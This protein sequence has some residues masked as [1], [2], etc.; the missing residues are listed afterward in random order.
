MGPGLL[1]VGLLAT[2]P[3]TLNSGQRKEGFMEGAGWPLKS[4][5][6]LMISRLEPERLLVF[7]KTLL[8]GEE[9]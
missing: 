2:Q 7:K 4:L 3:Q 5:H 9:E 1:E 8:E 6:Q